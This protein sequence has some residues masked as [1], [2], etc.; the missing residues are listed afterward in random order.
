MFSLEDIQ[1][2]FN[3]VGFASFDQAVKALSL[4]NSFIAAGFDDPALF[5]TVLKRFRLVNAQMLLKQQAAM[6][7]AAQQEEIRLVVEKTNPAIGEYNNAIAAI[8]AEL[9]ALKV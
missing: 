3:A 1:A 8:E 2:I 6:A 7:L 4:A 9:A 5:V